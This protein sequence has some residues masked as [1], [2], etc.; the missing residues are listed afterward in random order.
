MY[1]GI[2]KACRNGFS[3]RVVNEDGFVVVNGV[4][5]EIVAD[6]ADVI[7]VDND[8]YLV[9]NGIVMIPLTVKG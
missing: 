8:G 1:V 3:R 5:T 6:K 7:T 2:H 9:V 4:T